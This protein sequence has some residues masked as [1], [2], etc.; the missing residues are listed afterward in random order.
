MGVRDERFG[1][2]S[3]YVDSEARLRC[4]HPWRRIRAIVNEALAA[5]GRDL[6]LVGRHRRR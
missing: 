3:S 1:E 6:A 2:L 5:L 4:D